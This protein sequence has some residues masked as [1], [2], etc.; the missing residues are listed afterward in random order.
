MSAV[1]VCLKNSDV[2]MLAHVNNCK[3]KSN[4]AI[5]N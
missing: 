3:G 4:I 1:V 5:S 2:Q